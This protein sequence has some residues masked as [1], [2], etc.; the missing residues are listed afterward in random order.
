MNGL[1][2]PNESPLCQF[3]DEMN[4]SWLDRSQ[5]YGLLRFA[6]RISDNDKDNWFE[7]RSWWQIFRA[8]TFWNRMDSV[9][10]HV[11]LPTLSDEKHVSYTRTIYVPCAQNTR[12]RY[13]QCLELL[14]YLYSLI[15]G[16]WELSVY[17]LLH[18]EITPIWYETEFVLASSTQHVHKSPDSSALTKNS[19]KKSENTI[20]LS[21]EEQMWG[22]KTCKMKER[23]PKIR[24]INPI[25]LMAIN[26]LSPVGNDPKLDSQ[27]YRKMYFVS[28]ANKMVIFFNCCWLAHRRL[29][30][31]LWPIGC[32][33][34]VRRSSST[35]GVDS[36]EWLYQWNRWNRFDFIILVI[37]DFRLLCFG[38]CANHTMR[39]ALRHTE[40]K[41]NIRCRHILNQPFA[42]KKNAWFMAPLLLHSGNF[43]HPRAH[44]HAHMWPRKQHG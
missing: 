29:C 22:D 44:T 3:V 27:R 31:C 14:F 42:W 17:H 10:A 15:R 16:T 34:P 28:F 26:W 12:M 21:S 41:K 7:Q 32:P 9:L 38:H 23:Q 33:L 40:S 20:A 43:L 18:C 2:I 19:Q 8:V 30:C 5:M 36:V 25:S 39:R 6:K 1:S 24:E 37:L 4:L 13:V 11:Q 35:S